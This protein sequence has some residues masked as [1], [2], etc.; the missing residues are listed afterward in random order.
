MTSPPALKLRIDSPIGELSTGRG[1]YQLEE[2]TLYVQ[3]APFS[4]RHRFFSYLESEYVRL[5]LDMH[6]R[7]LF[8]EVSRPRRHWPVRD[9][10]ALP[11]DPSPADVRWLD[12]RRRMAD[13]KLMANP[14]R[15]ALLLRFARLPRA[16]RSYLLAE[17]VVAD[18]AQDNSLVGIWVGDIVDDIAGQFISSF[19]KQVRRQHREQHAT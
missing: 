18:V 16:V 7:L 6:G 5:D 12:F 4:R 1:F 10:L 2:D 9:G 15:T 17:S 3:V 11:A 13:P 14:Q 19:R 8:I